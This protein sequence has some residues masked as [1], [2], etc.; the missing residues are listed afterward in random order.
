MILWWPNAQKWL[1]I[2]VQAVVLGSSENDVV[3]T[4]YWI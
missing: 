3:G 4:E 1:K 2:L